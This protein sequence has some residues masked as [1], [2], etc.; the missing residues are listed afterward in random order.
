MAVAIGG[1]RLIGS[2]AWRATATPRLLWALAW[3]GS[4]AIARRYGV[5]RRVQPAADLED[6]AE[7]AAPVGFVGRKREASLDQRKGFVVAPLLMREQAGIVQCTRVIGRGLEHAA[8]DLM[9]R[10]ELLVLLQ[11]DRER[12]RFLER[13]LARGLCRFQGL[14]GRAAHVTLAR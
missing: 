1:F 10:R 3:P 8:V 13:Q 2:S 14:L 7:V 11:Q 5:D 4:I 12:H 9:R 6:N